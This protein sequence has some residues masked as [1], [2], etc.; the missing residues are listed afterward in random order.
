MGINHFWKKN[1]F[2]DLKRS[3]IQSDEEFLNEG[4]VKTTKQSLYVEGFI[5]RYVNANKVLKI[6]LLTQVDEKRKQDINQY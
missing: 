5:K 3:N 6:Y 2:K 4:D 1:E